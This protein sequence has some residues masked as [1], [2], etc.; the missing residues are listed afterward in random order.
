MLLGL[1]A[2]HSFTNDQNLIDNF[3][4]GERR[5]RSASLN[6]VLTSTGA[7]KAVA[8]ALPELAGKLTGNAIRVPTPNVSMAVANLNLEKGTDKEELNT[9]LREMALNSPLS[10]QIDYTDSTE[11]VSSDLVGSR[12]A[13]VVDGAATIA[14]DNRCVLYIWYDNEFGYSGQV[15]HCME[16]MMGVRYNTYPATFA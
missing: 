4:S 2:V 5:G 12:H 10:A 6:M 14:Q 8:K 1:P 3:H 9:Y 11:I 16:Q 15:V 13:G 7:A